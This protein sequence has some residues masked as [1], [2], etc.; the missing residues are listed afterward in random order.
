MTENYTQEELLEI[1]QAVFDQM[2]GLKSICIMTAAYNFKSEN[3]GNNVAVSW[4]FKG[5]RTYNYVKIL[6]TPR[7][8]YTMILGQYRKSQGLPILKIRSSQDNLL[9][10]DIKKYF[11][12]E[13]G[14]YLTLF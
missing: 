7:D 9:C 1:A 2:G 14:L 3:E 11:E 4:R 5:S 10:C 6:Y 8:D 12:Q 13:T